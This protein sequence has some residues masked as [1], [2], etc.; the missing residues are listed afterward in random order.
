MQIHWLKQIQC[1][2]YYVL[3]VKVLEYL[4]RLQGVN[5][6]QLSPTDKLD[7]DIFD[8]HLQTFLDG[9]RFDM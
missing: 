9:A 1:M 8:N 5:R 4:N 3:Q 6:E 7:Y 2:K